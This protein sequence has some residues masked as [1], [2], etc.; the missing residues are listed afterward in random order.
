MKKFLIS[1]ALLM[2]S[3]FPSVAQQPPPAQPGQAYIASIY[4]TY[5]SAVYTGNT[6]T[7]PTFI[8]AQPVTVNL[9]NGLTT[10]P[11]MPNTPI[12]V[13]RG[14]ANVETITPTVS[15]CF[16]GSISCTLAAT[17]TQKHVAGEPLTSGTFGLQEAINAATAN[18]TGT[19]IIDNTWRG[20]A[21]TALI[22]A[23]SGSVNV[24]IEDTR[25]GYPVW[26]GWNGSSYVITTIYALEN[27]LSTADGHNGQ[28]YGFAATNFCNTVGC[29]T[30]QA[31]VA[32]RTTAPGICKVF[33]TINLPG[34]IMF[35]ASS[36]ALTPQ[37]TM[38][39]SYINLSSCSTTI[40]SNTVT[41]ASTAGL[42]AGMA[43]GGDKTLGPGNYIASVTNSTTLQL[44]LPASR[45]LTAVI[46][47]SSNTVVGVDN[48]QDVAAGQVWNNIYFAANTTVSSIA[49]GAT[50]SLVMSSTSTNGSAVPVTLALNPG[51]VVSGLSLSAIAQTPVIL[52][53]EAANALKKP[54]GPNFGAGLSN[55]T[56][57]DPTYSYAQ[58]SFGRSLAGVIGVQIFGYDNYRVLNLSVNG[59][60]GS[61]LVLGGY[62]SPTNDNGAV[63]ESDFTHVYIYSSGDRLTGQAAVSLMTGLGSNASSGSGADELNQL[64][65]TD[66]HII[67]A[68]GD[69]LLIGTYLHAG[70]NNGPRLIWFEGDTQLEDGISP[71]Y[72]GNSDIVRILAGGK[73]IKFNGGEYAT[74]GFGKA[75]VHVDL[76]QD[77][78]VIGSNL[79]TVGQTSVYNVTIAN[80]S[81]TVTYVSS[82]TNGSTTGF[83]AA[84]YLNGMGA[85]LNDGASCTPCTVWLTPNNSV[86]PGRTAITLATNYTG[87]ATTATL[88]LTTGGYFF[89]LDNSVSLTQLTSTANTYGTVGSTVGTMLG[90]GLT[91]ELFLVGQN[92]VTPPPVIADYPTG[93]GI[94]GPITVGPSTAL[95]GPSNPLTIQDWYPNSSGVQTLGAVQLKLFQGTGNNPNQTLYFTCTICGQDFYNN[96]LNSNSGFGTYQN[97][98]ST[99]SNKAMFGAYGSTQG[100]QWGLNNGVNWTLRDATNSVN[101]ITVVPGTAQAT[102]TAPPVVPATYMQNT[103]AGPFTSLFD[104][105]VSA[106]AIAGG[107]VGSPT[108]AS[109]LLSSTKTD[110][111]HP[112]NIRLLSG[113]GTS[114]TGENC[115]EGSQPT[116]VSPQTIPVWTWE[117]VVEPEFLPATQASAYEVG[118]VAQNGQGVIPWVTGMG[119]YLSSVN[120]NANH[121][122]CAYGT[123]PTLVDSTVSATLAWTRL[124][125]V[126]NGTNLLWYIGGTQVCSVAI[127]SLPTASLYTGAWSA[128]TNTASTATALDV[129]YVNFIRQVTR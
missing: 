99:G 22:V 68:D 25:S 77:L 30:L 27:Y 36:C 48:L 34:P 76:G 62:V 24:V 6:T 41:C 15:N 61:G 127:A 16:P 86:N 114:G 118:L 59:L 46:Q 108:A 81:P 103:T 107:S 92:A 80:G 100:W 7:G 49:Y 113:T 123:T 84:T 64:G 26:Y 14:A 104:D 122:Y 101:A 116:I 12:S 120:A 67:S 35:D 129:D 125:L 11:F 82:N 4:G 89:N 102:F 105:F 112:G 56:I 94:V 119:F 32:L 52:V 121:W 53:P 106:A 117:S 29:S 51:T 115:V 38:A 17:F 37:S 54:H 69:N 75:T 9:S 96:I 55:V 85:L 20:P 18:Q 63:R 71:Y 21:G 43:I 93:G 65:F 39:Q 1:L 33:T 8:V 10:I 98:N 66:T 44:A 31:P 79:S 83:P 40:G 109:C 2:A 70:T 95:V 124:T 90:A 87:A 23:A 74:P 126:Q 45:L 42:V 19:V 50:Q 72:F 3:C 111:N 97:L 88:T 5:Q 28:D 128:V 91:T 57:T 73:T 58:N 47:P 78:S 60:N 110:I 13:D